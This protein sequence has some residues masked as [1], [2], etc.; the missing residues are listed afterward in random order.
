LLCHRNGPSVF[1]WRNKAQKWRPTLTSPPSPCRACHH[2]GLSWSRNTAPIT[3]FQESC[4]TIPPHPEWKR[5]FSQ[6]QT[7]SRTSAMLCDGI[8]R[9][10]CSQV[11]RNP[12]NLAPNACVCEEP[13]A[14]LVRCC[15][16][17]EAASRK[18]HA[19]F[20][21]KEQVFGSVDKVS[22]FVYVHKAMPQ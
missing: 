14:S 2:A 6:R 4:Q 16:E 5:K 12:S 7:S 20:W 9:K 19:A 3:I 21:C 13:D 10:A 22:R 8:P 1:G 11:Q 15:A 17:L 18:F